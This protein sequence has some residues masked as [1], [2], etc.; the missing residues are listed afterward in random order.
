MPAAGPNLDAGAVAH[1]AGDA[2]A[3][4]RAGN[5]K[6]H[7]PLGSPCAESYGI[8][9]AESAGTAEAGRGTAALGHWDTHRAPLEKKEHTAAETELALGAV[10][11][12]TL[13]VSQRA[14]H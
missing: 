8:P 12:F 13:P 11:Q 7:R 2:H 4:E 5:P 6:R 14:G 9:P 3:R 1:R 10:A